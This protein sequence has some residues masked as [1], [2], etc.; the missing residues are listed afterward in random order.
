MFM[1]SKQLSLRLFRLKSPANYRKESDSASVENKQPIY[2]KEG[3]LD[4][5][6]ALSIIDAKQHKD[7]DDEILCLIEWAERK[8]GTKPENSYCLNKDLKKKF[9]LVLCEFYE[10]RLK[11]PNRK[12]KNLK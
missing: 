1:R 8:D 2:K 5:D 11:F 3:Y 9:P 6:T 4:Y 7:I 10:T 12:E